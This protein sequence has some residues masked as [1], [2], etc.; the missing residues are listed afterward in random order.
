MPRGKRNGL[1]IAGGGLAGSL[2]ALAMAKAR[3]DVPI[4]LVEERDRFGG[5][6]IWTFLDC[7]LDE[8]QRALIEPLISF[9]WPGHYV[10]FPDYSRKLRLGVNGIRSDMLDKAVREALR[11]DQY[12]LDTKVVA[13][14]E[15]ELVL[16]D[17]E[18]IRADGAIDARG[19]A[20][21]SLLELG[22]RK[23][24]GRE[25]SFEKP[26]RVDMPVLMDATVEQVDGFRFCR[27]LPLSATRLLVK[28]CCL[29]E[30]PD[31]ERDEARARIAAYC[32]LRGWK[33]GTL[34]REESSVLPIALGDDVH[35]LWRGGG[36]RV[37]K[38]G[39]RGGFFHPSTGHAL[40][41]A[42]RTALLL[43]QQRSFEGDM[44]DDLFEADVDMLW[45]KREYYRAFNAALFGAPAL[46]RRRMM[47]A[48]HHLDGDLIARFYAGRLG[49]VDRLKLSGIRGARPGR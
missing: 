34:E 30:T 46:E 8:E 21:L 9:S 39:M 18:V 32:A 33:N 22:W 19:A 6:H 47:D 35:A 28:D 45:R 41:D 7:E 1:L 14:R 12:R 26:H 4:L 36:A 49:V 48:F 43:A 40:A 24:V 29:S 44:L 20:N 37:A 25:Y 16:P 17:G 42:A 13:V 2:A 31:L 27:C 3:P 23:F 10:A 38:L 15:T 5:D 11:P